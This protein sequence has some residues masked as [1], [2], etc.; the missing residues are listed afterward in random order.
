MKKAILI[1]STL[2]IMAL[3]GALYGTH[4]EHHNQECTAAEQVLMNHFP[5]PMPEMV[6][7]PI[8]GMPVL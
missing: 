2:L 1:L 5:H 6:V 3:A 4:T 8:V 7:D